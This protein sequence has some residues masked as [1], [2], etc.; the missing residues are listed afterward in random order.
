MAAIGDRHEPVPTASVDRIRAG[1]SDS[2]KIE[3]TREGLHWVGDYMIEAVR[4]G[5][6]S[7]WRSPCSI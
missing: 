3:L 7:H 1:L 6:I 2:L 4:R 5:R